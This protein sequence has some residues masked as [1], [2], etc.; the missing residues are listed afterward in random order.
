MATIAD[1]IGRLEQMRPRLARRLQA[2][3]L[4]DDELKAILENAGIDPDDDAQL[5]VAARA[6]R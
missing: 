6:E 2:H 4:T 3:E 1:R 5:N